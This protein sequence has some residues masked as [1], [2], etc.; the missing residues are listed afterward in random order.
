MGIIDFSATK[1][2]YCNKSNKISTDSS[3]EDGFYGAFN[4]FRNNDGSST[5]GESFISK[6]KGHSL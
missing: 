2:K 6:T 5:K 4:K 3:K 1:V